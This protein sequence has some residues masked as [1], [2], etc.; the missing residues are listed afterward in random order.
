MNTQKLHDHTL[1]TN[2]CVG[3]EPITFEMLIMYPSGSLTTRL[4][5]MTKLI[6]FILILKCVNQKM[7]TYLACFSL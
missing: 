1:H 3:I 2:V 7:K 5:D 6:T 4:T